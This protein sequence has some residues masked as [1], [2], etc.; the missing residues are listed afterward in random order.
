[1][2]LLGILFYLAVA[3]VA[4]AESRPLRIVCAV[5]L[6]AFGLL[7]IADVVW[8]PGEWADLFILI[9][10]ALFIL[11]ACEVRRNYGKTVSWG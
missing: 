8:G 6:V 2:S 3:G 10:P 5:V 7:C 9:I 1:M 4:L 11:Y